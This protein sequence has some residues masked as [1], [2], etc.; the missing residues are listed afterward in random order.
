QFYYVNHGIFA[1]HLYIFIFIALL[2]IFSL[3]KINEHAHINILHALINILIIGLFIYEYL[4]MKNF[5][6]QG[7]IKTFFKFLLL[8]IFFVIALGL[9]FTIFIVFSFF[10]I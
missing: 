8:D 4:A 6:R 2:I 10:N 7:W 3:D 5:Y 9:V 1:I